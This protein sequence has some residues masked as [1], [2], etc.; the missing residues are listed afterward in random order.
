METNEGLELTT[1]RA[2]L[3]RL[4]DWAPPGA[5]KTRFLIAVCV[6]G[7]AHSHTHDVFSQFPKTQIMFG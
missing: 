3:G 5:L 4:T 7:G 1:L 6:W 2:R